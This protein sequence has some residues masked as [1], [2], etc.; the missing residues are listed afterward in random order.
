MIHV[1]GPPR[2]TV[3]GLVSDSSSLLAVCAGNTNGI[4]DTL[5]QVLE[6]MHL[7]FPC[8]SLLKQLD[9]VA[10]EMREKHAVSLRMQVVQCDGGQ[11]DEEYKVENCITLPEK[12]SKAT[13]SASAKP[14][15]TEEGKKVVNM[16]LEHHQHRKLEVQCLSIMGQKGDQAPAMGLVFFVKRKETVTSDFF[17]RFSKYDAMSK[18]ELAALV[19]ERKET[20][21]YSEDVPVAFFGS[22][23]EIEHTVL[24]Y[25]TEACRCVYIKF[26]GTV[27]E[28]AE[29]MGIQRVTISGKAVREEETLLGIDQLMSSSAPL[30]SDLEVSG[31]ILLTRILGFLIQMLVD[32]RTII[33]RMQVHER[34]LSSLTESHLCVE[35]LSL[36]KIWSLYVP[37]AISPDPSCKSLSHLCLMLLLAALPFMAETTTGKERSS[38][39]TRGEVSQTILSHL[40]SLI[41]SA[42]EDPQMQELAKN[43]VVS[44]VPVF[45]PTVRSR[46]EHLMGMFSSVGKA[47]LTSWMLKFKGL[48]QYFVE[49]DSFKLL[50]LPYSPKARDDINID[51]VVD[52]LDRIVGV[53]CNQTCLTLKGEASLEAEMTVELLQSIQGSLFRWC[54]RHLDAKQKD[55]REASSVLII[56]YSLLLMEKAVDLL[57]E[58]HRLQQIEDVIEK[59]PKTVIGCVVPQ[60]LFFLNSITF[61]S[62]FIALK[63]L[64]PLNG[65][66]EAVGSIEKQ[67]PNLF[68]VT[69]PQPDSTSTESNSPKQEDGKDMYVLN[70]WVREASSGAVHEVHKEEKFLAPGATRMTVDFD[71]CCRVERQYDKLEFIS[72]DTSNTQTLQGAVGSSDWPS[73]IEFKGSELTFRF[74][75][76]S[77]SGGWA[78]KY[79]VRAYGPQPQSMGPL[80]DLQLTIAHLM[81]RFCSFMMGSQ[82][83]QHL[84]EAEDKDPAEE[85][86]KELSRKAESWLTSSDAWKKLFRGGITEK[87][88]RT[89]STRHSSIP[90]GSEIN[91]MLTNMASGISG[92][93]VLEKCKAM[94]RGPQMHYGGA[95]VDQA[96]H[97]VFAALVWHSQQIREELAAAGEQWLHCM[98]LRPTPILL[99]ASLLQW[100]CTILCNGSDACEK[101]G[102]GGKS[103]LVFIVHVKGGEVGGPVGC[104]PGVLWLR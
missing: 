26:I 89:L 35:G 81:G 79:I 63:L 51:G 77:S 23:E 70:M 87:F 39:D 30:G 64:R 1:H 66:L 11:K 83:Q 6:N 42:E 38:G 92:H 80:A 3:Y 91:E 94:H 40:C 19:S 20:D 100:Y 65:L 16:I 62:N 96:L 84:K 75:V 97:A 28:N 43:V 55:L 78:Y 57:R 72:A 33:H 104:L 95:V 67:H 46:Q 76:I 34:D 9:D 24:P 71:Q 59:L 52:V 82:R 58:L 73:H 56:N 101:I 60:L 44:G 48:C 29:R 36:E 8:R 12:T 32:L 27:G 2:V 68:I 90:A 17:E 54:S 85:K 37:L 14:Y 61:P 31:S 102:A 21:R 98:V 10:K 49:K 86:G 22:T 5:Q 41:D 50:Q 103:M 18:T 4:L 74:N 7:L 69:V 93:E 15:V 53:A 45:F 88:T 13:L 47:Q 25:T 99:H